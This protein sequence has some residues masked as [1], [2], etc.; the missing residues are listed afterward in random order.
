MKNSEMEGGPIMFGSIVDHP[1]L[2]QSFCFF[3]L[4]VFDRLFL[5]SVKCHLEKLLILWI[6]AINFVVE[7]V[8]RDIRLILML[9]KTGTFLFKKGTFLFFQLKRRTER[10]SWKWI[11]DRLNKNG[12]FLSYFKV[13]EVSV[14]L[15]KLN[16]AIIVNHSN[17]LLLQFNWSNLFNRF[18]QIINLPFRRNL[19]WCLLE[20]APFIVI[21]NEDFHNLINIK[22]N[23]LTK[24]LWSEIGRSDYW[25]LLIF[26]IS[27]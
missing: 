11:V 24:N 13:S 4:I 10:F 20:L 6:V 1:W 7:G 18:L 19:K 22:M 23:Q 2:N 12:G 9:D 21:F 16:F 8:L 15:I 14:I 27:K 26:V 17:D 3:E 25:A 5:I